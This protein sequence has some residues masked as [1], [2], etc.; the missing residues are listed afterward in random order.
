MKKYQQINRQRRNRA[1]RVSNAV[2]RY[3]DRP[4]LCV[5]RSN[6]HIY[7]QIIN[8]EQGST[9]VSASTRDKDLR[10]DIKNGGNCNAA[11]KVGT[12]IASKALA[13]GITKVVFDRHGFKYHGRVKALA[14]AARNAGLGI[15]AASVKEKETE[16]KTAPK[17][18][19]VSKEAKS[20]A[21]SASKV[22][23]GKASSNKTKA[24]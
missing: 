24:K 3:A 15:G 17:K 2:K 21:K 5:F 18:T 12:A 23:D 1:F 4:R 9:L 7:A 6:T 8:D 19:K 22:A 11:D 14:E 10:S 20:I 13:A 16:K